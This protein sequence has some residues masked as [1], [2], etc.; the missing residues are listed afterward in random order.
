MIP[1]TTADMLTSRRSSAD[2]DVSLNKTSGPHPMS[3][4][5]RLGNAKEMKLDLFAK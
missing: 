3:F 5:P 1:R 2:P 4:V